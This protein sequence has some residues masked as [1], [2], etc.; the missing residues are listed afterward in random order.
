M[1]KKTCLTILAAKNSCTAFRGAGISGCWHSVI[2][3]LECLW[4]AK[5]N[6]VKTVLQ[7]EGR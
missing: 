6:T 5:K 2:Q 3:D 4:L 7:T 1:L